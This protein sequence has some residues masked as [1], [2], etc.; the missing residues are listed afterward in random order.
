MT[1]ST[2]RLAC[3]ELLPSLAPHQKLM[4]KDPEAF[5]GKVDLAWQ[6]G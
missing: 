5:R 2:S 4:R 6:M 3:E 1:N